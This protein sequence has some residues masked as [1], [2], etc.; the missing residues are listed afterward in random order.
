MQTHQ[1]KIFKFESSKHTKPRHVKSVR[2]L[3][4]AVTHGTM[5]TQVCLLHAYK[6][7]L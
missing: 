6:Y 4:R 5:E 3:W 1:I 7:F 2:L